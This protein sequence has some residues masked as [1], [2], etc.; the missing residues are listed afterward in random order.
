M[1]GLFLLKFLNAHIHIR[2]ILYMIKISKLADYS[3]VILVALAQEPCDLINAASLAELTKLPEPTV[4]KIL[5]LLAKAD[6][7]ESTR[8]INGGYTLGKDPSEISVEQ[9]VRAID[10]PVVIAACAEVEGLEPDCNLIGSCSVRGRWDGVNEAIRNALS[11]VHLSD[12]LDFS[13]VSCC[14]GGNNS[15]ANNKLLSGKN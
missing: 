14:A 11:K 6:I 9:I 8:G 10:G 13:E 15:S 2:R 5:K 1:Y 12:M 3:V 7:V 4:A